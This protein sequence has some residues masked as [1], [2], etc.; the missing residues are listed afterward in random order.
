MP[1]NA[2]ALEGT[3]GGNTDE[4]HVDHPEHH[5]EEIT[6]D[7]GEISQGGPGQTITPST[8]QNDI[9]DYP[10][11]LQVETRVNK[12]GCDKTGHVADS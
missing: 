5:V 2:P 6:M 11:H 9:L 3:E 8:T 4:A 12:L 7:I 1:E 10:C